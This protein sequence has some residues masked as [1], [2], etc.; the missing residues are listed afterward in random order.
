MTLK[1]IID[2]NIENYLEEENLIMIHSNHLN[3]L[4]AIEKK[5]FDEIKIKN[6]KTD[7]L[8]SK[9]LFNVSRCLKDTGTCEIILDQPIAV[10][11]KLDAGELEANAK[12][13]G[14]NNVKIED[15]E[16]ISKKGVPIN[17][18]TLKLTLTK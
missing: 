5:F 15:Y 13:G 11:Q 7:L 4:N 1:L 10:M 6:T 2:N 16:I 18:S 12:L 14:F 17:C 9:V 8:T 3:M